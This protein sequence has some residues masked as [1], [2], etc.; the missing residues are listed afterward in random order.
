MADGTVGARPTRSGQTIVRCR[1]GAEIP[2]L[3]D[4]A[5]MDRAIMMHAESHAKKENDPEKAEAVFVEIQDYL[6]KQVLAAAG[7]KKEA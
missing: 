2:L 7:G 6:I 3:P 1:C 4:V 5:E